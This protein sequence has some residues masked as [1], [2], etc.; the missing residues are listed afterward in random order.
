[1]KKYSLSTV[2]LFIFITA[3]VWAGCS[4]KK[5][6]KEAPTYSKQ[7]ADSK[8][9]A[10]KAETV[11]PK[12]EKAAIQKLDKT[13][14][15][16]T[17]APKEKPYA[18]SPSLKTA[19]AKKCAV[20]EPVLLGTHSQKR[21]RALAVDFGPK[22]GLAAWHTDKSSIQTVSLE[23]DGRPRGVAKTL[24]LYGSRSYLEIIALGDRF[25]VSAHD[26][27]RDDRLFRKCVEYITVD[28]QGD[29]VGQP[30]FYQT[31]E[32]IREQLMARVSGDTVFLGWGF[33]YKNPDIAEIALLDEKTARLSV[34]PVGSS[35]E[36]VFSSPYGL[37]AS[38]SD[39][40]A[41]ARDEL[42]QNNIGIRLFSGD[43]PA[44]SLLRLP[45]QIKVHRMSLMPSDKTI[46]LIFSP[47]GEKG[48][49]KPRLAQLDLN[50]KLQQKPKLLTSLSQLPESISSSMTYNVEEKKGR[51][52]LNR[53]DVAG[54]NIGVAPI[55][56]AS[57]GPRDHPQVDA[58]W[59]GNAFVIVYSTF[60]KNRWSVYSVQAICAPETNGK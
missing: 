58:A 17:T 54:N 47:M 11:A 1:M 25:W 57:S 3:S 30:A 53:F 27:C 34:V 7:E 4:D 8:A 19:G 15:A 10:T 16:E 23:N 9:D 49:L 43:G 55:A 50:G 45:E 21:L 35:L 41:L 33:T 12:V 22:G 37:T 13:K 36:D 6:P 46:S 60:E 32:W 28:G 20:S 56:S 14:T 40:Y 51:L 2:C 18:W 38:K 48:P 5:A 31:Q 39:W 59:N 24:E 29:V 26:L 44:R 42:G 52:T